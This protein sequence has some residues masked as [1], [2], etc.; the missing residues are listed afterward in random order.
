M[1]HDEFT[2]VTFMNLTYL[3]PGF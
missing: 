2:G 3:E 1:T